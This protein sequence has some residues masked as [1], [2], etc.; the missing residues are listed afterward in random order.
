MGFLGSV[1]IPAIIRRMTPVAPFFSMAAIRSEILLVLFAA[2]FAAELV[3]TIN[4]LAVWAALFP[5]RL[6]F[7]V[8]VSRSAYLSDEGTPCPFPFVASF[9]SR[10][11]PLP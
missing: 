11:P 6:P 2:Y 10:A 9:A 8:A 3:G 1:G 4:L 5:V 7:S